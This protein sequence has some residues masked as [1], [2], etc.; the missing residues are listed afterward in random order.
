M[1][2]VAELGAAHL[3]RDLMTE[4]VQV[5]HP[6]DPLAE[7]HERMEQLACRHMPVVDEEGDLVGLVTHRDLLR[8]ALIEQPEVPRY[9]ESV[10]LGRLTV[11]QVMVQEV[12]TAEPR[13]DLRQA[14]Q[15]MLD[16]KFGCLPVVEGRRLVGILTESDFVRRVALTP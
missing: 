2:A 10:L 16:N 9:V 11:R 1:N 3:V 6:D 5:A 12:E 15:T 8:H 14:A 13:T 7:V 4:A